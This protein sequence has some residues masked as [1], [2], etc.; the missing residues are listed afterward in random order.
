MMPNWPRS[1]SQRA[2]V[3]ARI[4]PL[5]EEEARERQGRRTDIRANWPESENRRARD[6]AAAAAHVS[7]RS[8]E[9]ASKV[10]REGAPELIAQVD[11]GALS[12][13]AAAEIAELEPD[14]QR[15]VV[16][17]G[18]APCFSAHWREAFGHKGES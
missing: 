9:R 8:V 4:K 15:E 18:K 13:G 6:D 2:M 14:E 1:E 3:G 17:V 5:F 7:S 10:L 11:A 12:V 16:A